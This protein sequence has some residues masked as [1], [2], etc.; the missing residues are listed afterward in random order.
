M[1]ESIVVN[2]LNTMFGN[3]VLEL[4]DNRFENLCVQ[5]L[6]SEA[7]ACKILDK[8]NGKKVWIT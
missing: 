4:I 8:K 5:R 1:I 3:L 7:V 6:I 2:I